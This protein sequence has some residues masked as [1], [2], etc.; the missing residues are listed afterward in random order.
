MTSQQQ[1]VLAYYEREATGVIETQ[2]LAGLGLSAFRAARSQ[3]LEMGLLAMSLR[4]RYVPVVT[5]PDVPRLRDCES[6]GKALSMRWK[7]GTTLLQCDG[8]GAEVETATA[9]PKAA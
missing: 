6:C 9:Q 1:A 8:C 5:V 7:Q 3:L 2:A 4:G